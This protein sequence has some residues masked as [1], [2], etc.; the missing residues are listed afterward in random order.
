MAGTM[1]DKK[2]L[3]SI[4]TPSYNQGEFIE[5]TLLS[6][7]RQTYPKIEHIVVDGGSTDDTLEI[8][9]KYEGEYTMRWV[10]ESDEGQTDA[11]NKGFDMAKGEIVAWLNSDDIYLDKKVIEDVVDFFQSHN[12]ADIV[13][14]GTIHIDERGRILYFLFT[15]PWISFDLLIRE[16]RLPQPSVFFRREVVKNNKLCTNLEYSMDYEFWLRLAT[17]GTKFFHLNRF[18]SAF[19]HHSKSKTETAKAKQLLESQKVRKIYGNKRNLKDRFLLRFDDLLVHFTGIKM[20][21]DVFRIYNEKAD[22]L[23]IYRSI[24][25]FSIVLTVFRR[26]GSSLGKLV[27]P[28]KLK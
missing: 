18:I 28:K 14:G 13:Y 7:K 3:V 15:P 16:N 17:G 9:K 21:K 26:I 4:V 27:F 10:S 19:R 22:S 23:F 8:L 11:I 6:V 20:L 25:L 24:P 2:P 12:E 1:L 5:D